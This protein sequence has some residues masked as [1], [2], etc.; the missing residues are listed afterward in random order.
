MKPAVAALLA[1]ALAAA[2]HAQQH[3]TGA[4]VSGAVSD[5]SGAPVGGASVSIPRPTGEKATSAVPT[6]ALA[7]TSP[8]SG[9]RVC[10]EYSDCTAATLC[11]AAA[12]RSDDGAI[13][14]KPI[15]RVLPF[16]PKIS[17]DSA[18]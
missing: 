16:S 15:A 9:S 18:S 5:A 13:S 10:S 12:R 7:C 8:S 6:P 4:T 3:V 11:T 17:S 2:A 14:E 1:V